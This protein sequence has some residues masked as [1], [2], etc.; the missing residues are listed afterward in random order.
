MDLIR[1]HNTSLLTVM[2]RRKAG[3]WKKQTEDNVWIWDGRDCKL[4]EK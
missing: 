4:V 1:S 2:G 3:D